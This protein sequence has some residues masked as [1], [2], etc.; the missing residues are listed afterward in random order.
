[1]KKWIL[2]VFVLTVAIHGVATAQNDTLTL[3]RPELKEL[4]QVIRQDAVQDTVDVKEKRAAIIAIQD[5]LKTKA[6]A[7]VV[8]VPRDY[9]LKYI[10]RLTWDYEQMARYESVK[11]K[12][13]RISAQYYAKDPTLAA[14]DKKN[15]NGVPEF[16]RLNDVKKKIRQEL[17]YEATLNKKSYDLKTEE[18][19]AAIINETIKE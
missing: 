7:S 17:K 8:I 18:A 5:V 19:K 2:F 4:L 11:N 6:A 13:L 12:L 10:D 14:L 9:I 3:A 15:G 16:Y 1:M